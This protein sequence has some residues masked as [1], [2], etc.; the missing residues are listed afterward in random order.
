LSY[1]LHLTWSRVD[2]K[3]RRLRPPNTHTRPVPSHQFANDVSEDQNQ[4][5]L[6]H[7]DHQPCPEQFGAGLIRPSSIIFVWNNRRDGLQHTNDI[8][9]VIFAPSLLTRWRR[10]RQKRKGRVLIKFCA[11]N[12]I[13]MP[14]EDISSAYLFNL[15]ITL[16]SR[17][18]RLRSSLPCHEEI[19]KIIWPK[20]RQ[21][22][23]FVV[24][25]HAQSLG[26]IS[27]HLM[28]EAEA[29]AE[30]EMSYQAS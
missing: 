17:L 7:S 19:Q 8:I 24:R 10:R 18:G 29:E 1:L 2:F 13:A 12:E 3:R 15:S 20:G 27:V 25:Q 21:C 30:A 4:S 5:E 16:P 11:A 14:L 9:I 23:P 26:V 22:R 28:A 6:F